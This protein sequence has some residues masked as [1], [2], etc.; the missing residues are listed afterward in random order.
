MPELA[1]AETIRRDLVAIYQG[2]TISSVEVHR[3]RSV[4]R[5]PDPADLILWLALG[6][7]LLA[8]LAV[9]ASILR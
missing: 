9:A 4:R 5:H 7:A 3:S 6:V 1:E 2:L 8:A